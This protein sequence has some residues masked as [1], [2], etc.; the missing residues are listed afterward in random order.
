MIYYIQTPKG[1]ERTDDPDDFGADTANKL[2]FSADNEESF[3]LKLDQFSEI[4][5]QQNFS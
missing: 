3:Q 2:I 1:Y 5:R 4:V